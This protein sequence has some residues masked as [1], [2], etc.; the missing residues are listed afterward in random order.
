M[1]D[2]IK[3]GKWWDKPL[4]LNVGCTEV[5][6]ECAGCWEREVALQQVSIYGERTMYY[7]LLTDSGKWTGK[8]VE[9]PANL[10]LPRPGQTPKCWA[11][12]TDL[13]HSGVSLKMQFAAFRLFLECKNHLFVVCTKRPEIAVGAIKIIRQQIITEATQSLN[14]AQGIKFRETLFDNVI[15]MT[16]AGTQKNYDERITHLLNVPLKH[17]ALSMEPLLEPISLRL[18]QPAS[19]Y[20]LKGH[21][22]PMSEHICWVITGGETENR[23]FHDARPSN[24]HWFEAIRLQCSLYG[25]DY[26]HKHNGCFKYNK[27]QTFEKVGTKKAGRHLFGQT[28]NGVPTRAVKSLVVTQVKR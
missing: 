17:K 11:V 23:L 4:T 15:I 21:R 20:G 6:T 7:G 1:F 22:E 28:Y 19:I 8:T 16:T 14:E 2:D 9:V 18:D 12:W 13:F 5:S 25:V 3:K 26:L 10:H 27:D 24:P